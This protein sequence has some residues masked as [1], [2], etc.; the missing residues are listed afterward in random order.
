MVIG[1][2]SDET[3]SVLREVADERYRQDEKWG[4]QNHPDGTGYPQFKN[5]ADIAKTVCDRAAKDGKLTY[6][7]ILEEEFWEALAETDKSKLRTELRQVAA[8]AVAWIEKI[9][10]D[11]AKEKVDGA[12]EG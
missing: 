4:E 12:K 7:H 11:I 3:K 1:E 10:R 9:D 8:V 6:A 5:M 2:S